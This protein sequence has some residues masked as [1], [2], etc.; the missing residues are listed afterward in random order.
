MPFNVLGPHKAIDALRRE[1]EEERGKDPS[2][3]GWT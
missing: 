3:S 1:I 2:Y